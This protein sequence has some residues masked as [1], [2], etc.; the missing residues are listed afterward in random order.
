MT[1]FRTPRNIT[2]D[3]KLPCEVCGALTTFREGKENTVR[4]HGGHTQGPHHAAY[5]I[6][7]RR[8]ADGWVPLTLAL[9]SAALSVGWIQRRE[10]DRGYLYLVA[11]DSP[12]EQEGQ[13]APS[14]FRGEYR[15]LLFWARIDTL[16]DL[17][18]RE[19]DLG[20]SHVAF[21]RTHVTRLERAAR[22]CAVFRESWWIAWKNAVDKQADLFGTLRA[23]AVT[24]KSP[25]G[26]RG[27]LTP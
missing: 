9:F 16:E 8:V 2:S 15:R 14:G 5:E 27:D 11:K 21:L 6:C 17:L 1:G 23:A 22:R 10:G 25:E 7:E 4:R 18:L 26:H 24:S 3:P 12:L 13:W 20:E 19:S